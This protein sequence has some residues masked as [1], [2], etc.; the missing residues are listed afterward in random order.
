MV[1]ASE[2]LDQHTFLDS[3]GDVRLAADFVDALDNVIDAPDAQVL[4]MA[5]V[6]PEALEVAPELTAEEARLIA[7]QDNWDQL[8]D[9]MSDKHSSHLLALAAMIN[10]YGERP[11]APVPERVQDDAEK[12]STT[13]L[14]AEA[15]K[16]INNDPFTEKAIAKIRNHPT[17]SDAAIEREVVELIARRR[18]QLEINSKP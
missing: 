8:L 7:Q 12:P 9:D 6:A 2:R 16:A 5:Y 13:L 11:I 1:H 4:D 18:A 17:K 15:I 10:K 14:G 3:D